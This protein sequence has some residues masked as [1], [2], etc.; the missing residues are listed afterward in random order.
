[1]LCGSECPLRPF[2]SSKAAIPLSAQLRPFSFAP[3]LTVANSVL[4]SPMAHASQACTIVCLTILPPFNS[5]MA[6]QMT[7]L[8]SG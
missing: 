6:E 3:V 7:R 5:A 4:A 8:P 2:L 1:M